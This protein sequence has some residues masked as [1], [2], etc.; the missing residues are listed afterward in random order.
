MKKII[1]LIL[2]TIFLLSLIFAAVA[3]SQPRLKPYFQKQLKL[4]FPE[5]HRPLESWHKA[6]AKLGQP[7]TL[8][9]EGAVGARGKG[10]VHYQ[11]DEG[12]V[13]V[14]GKGVVAVKGTEDVI[15][16][17]WGGKNQVGDWTFYWGKERLRAKGEDFN[18]Y[19]LN[20]YIFSFI[21]ST[22]I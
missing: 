6:Q 20:F 5:K 16:K 2:V 22:I 12:R 8:E 15:A 1:T 4:Y 11:V 10:K 7:V 21:F 13:R 19:L 14:S 3:F 9:G 17:G 18:F